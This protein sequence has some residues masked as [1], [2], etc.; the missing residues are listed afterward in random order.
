MLARLLILFLFMSI[1]A[2]AGVTTYD[3]VFVTNDIY[4]ADFSE[5]L[6]ENFERSLTGGINA[7]S[8]ANVVNDT[9]TEADMAD[10]IN[11]RVRTYE[12]AACEFVYTGLEVATSASL[13]T[14]ISAGTAYPLGYRINKAS[15]TNKTFTASKDTYVDLDINGDFQYSEVANGGAVPS[16]ASNSIRLSKVVT[17]GTAVTTVTDLALRNCA[18]GPFE[19]LKD[20]STGASL[21]DLLANGKPTLGRG[22]EGF[23]QGCNISWTSHTTFT[24]DACAAY[25]NGEYRIIGTSDVVAQTADAPSSGT[26]GIDTGA[27][28]GSTLYN[29][30]IMADEENVNTLSVSYGTGSTPSGGTNYR[31]IGEIKTDSNSLFTSRDIVITNQIFGK[32]FARGWVKLTGT[33]TASIDKS[34]NVSGIVDN[35]TGD[36]TI[37]WDTDFLDAKYAVGT[38]AYQSSGSNNVYIS[39]A[40]NTATPM[41]AGTLVVQC[42]TDAGTLVDCE[43]V[44]VVA[45]GDQL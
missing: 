7:T 43:I 29:V 27:I 19:D 41:T 24:V 35:G 13:S 39:G 21:E 2:Y 18:Q 42:S 31:K 11:P 25:V 5:R 30:F 34:Y 37:T 12:G 10:E 32:E 17:S 23:L 28:A 14:T 16:V 33:G 22:T 45:F 38:F 40:K 9:L 44:N 1:P 4:S 36:Y 26:S 3:N 15:S 8:T 6:N 20:E